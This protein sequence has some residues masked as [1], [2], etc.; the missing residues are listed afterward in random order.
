MFVSSVKRL[1]PAALLLFFPLLAA[2]LAAAPG[3]VVVLGSYNV[4]NLFDLKRDGSEYPGY[5][6]GGRLGWN[7]QMASVKIRHLARVIDALDADILALQEV[8]SRQVLE[9]LNQRLASPYP[10]LAAAD[11]K[12]TAVRCALLSR[13]PIAETETIAV[14]GSGS[15]SILKARLQIGR[16]PLV[17]FVN[18]WKSKSAPESRRLPYARAL[19]A[20]IEKLPPGADFVVAGDLN[21]NYNEFHTLAGQP[22][23]NDTGGVT[24]INHIL[25][26]TSDGRLVSERRLRQPG[27]NARLLY[28]PWLELKKRRR[29]SV[30]YYGRPGSPDHLLLSSG[31]YDEKGISYIDN[32]FD[33]FDPDLLFR[34][35]AIYRWQRAQKGRGRHLGKGFSDHL[36]LFLWLAEK[37]FQR[38]R[39]VPYPL[40]VISIAQLY[41]SKTGRVNCRLKNCAVIYTHRKFTVIK[42]PGGRAILIYGAAPALKTGR[43]YHLTARRLKRYYGML[44]ITRVVSVRPLERSVDPADY[45]ISAKAGPLDAPELCNEVLG[46]VRGLYKNGWLYYCGDRRIRLFTRNKALLPES[47]ARVI[48]KGIRIGYHNHPELVLERPGQIRAAGD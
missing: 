44:E 7:Q 25:P 17:V 24:G 20:E 40:E 32:S 1:L 12:S 16:A 15:R 26:T 33:K 31:L 48:L 4:E 21:S 8:E 46:R 6:P 42:Q 28:N 45:F 3:D 10:H 38:R 39:T 13:C 14:P 22:E 41:H 23:L 30:R 35:S 29:W 9:M 18:H 47:G 36:P 34:G 2:P 27:E 5:V 11:Q 19:A 43:M 37:P